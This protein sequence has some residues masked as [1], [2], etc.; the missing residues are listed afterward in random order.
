VSTWPWYQEGLRF[1]CTRCGACCSGFAGTVRVTGEE[2]ALLA[3]RLGVSEADF[4]KGY[5]R[6]VGAC[7]LSLQETGELDCVFYDRSEGCRVYEA[8]P[9]QCRTWPF[10]GRV[11]RTPATW[12]KQA[13]SCPGMN[14]GPLVDAETIRRFSEDDGTSLDSPD[15]GSGEGEAAAAVSPAAK[16]DV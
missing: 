1:E 12:E 6:S 4:R 11:V 7:H 2:V 15:A 9:K 16:P 14:D 10:W 8:R 5:T 3:R 13:E